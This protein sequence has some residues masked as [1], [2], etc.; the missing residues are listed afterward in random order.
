[1]PETPKQLP[2]QAFHEGVSKDGTAVISIGPLRVVVIPDGKFWFAQGLEIDYAAQGNDLEDAKKNFQDG[3]ISSVNENLKRFGT[4]KKLMRPA[5]PE[6]W[7]DMLY[8]PLSNESQNFMFIQETVHIIPELKR[9]FENIEFIQ[10]RA[11]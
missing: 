3:L 5:P 2:P 1:M 7:V 6:V 9:L 10:Q 11:A 4:I 8:G